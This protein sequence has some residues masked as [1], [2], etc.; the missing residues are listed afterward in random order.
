MGNVLT[1]YIPLNPRQFFFL[2]KPLH[3]GHSLYF[4]KD[5]FLKGYTI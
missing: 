2:S 1:V 3:L 4:M 5:L